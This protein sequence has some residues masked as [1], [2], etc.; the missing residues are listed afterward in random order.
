MTDTEIAVFLSQLTSNDTRLGEQL[1]R[2]ADAV[3]EL[4]KR[5][6]EILELITAL[7]RRIDDLEGKVNQ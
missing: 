1:R 6:L 5:N 4:S 7:L 3:G 2:T